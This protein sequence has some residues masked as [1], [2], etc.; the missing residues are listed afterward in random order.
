[1]APPNI[2]Y[3]EVP[4]PA[5]WLSWF[6]TKQ[7]VLGFFPPNPASSLAH[8]VV[9]GTGGAAFGQAITGTSG[10]FLV[11]QGA[12]LD[13]SFVPISG[14]VSA[15]ASGVLTVHNVPAASFNSSFLTWFAALPTSL[16]GSAGVAWNNGGTIAVS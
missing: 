7:D 8:S 1:M 9:L 15:T 14:D 16:P 5:Q 11:D 12:G 13:P 2:Y 10:Q 6:A 3:S 4:T